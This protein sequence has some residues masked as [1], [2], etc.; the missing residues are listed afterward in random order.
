MNP[1]I[2]RQMTNKSLGSLSSRFADKMNSSV[3]SQQ[4]IKKSAGKEYENEEEGE[5]LDLC[6]LGMESEDLGKSSGDSGAGEK[7]KASKTWTV[8]PGINIYS[9]CKNYE[10]ESYKERIICPLACN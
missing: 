6:W 10:C 5:G 1:D 2:L 3:L 9:Y 4:I 7:K 8:Y